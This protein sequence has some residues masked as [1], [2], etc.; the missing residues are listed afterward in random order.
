MGQITDALATLNAGQLRLAFMFFYVL[1]E[2]ESEEAL[3]AI[4]AARESWPSS[5][6]DQE[7]SRRQAVPSAAS[8]PRCAPA[9][10]RWP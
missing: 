10:P 5:L 1:A 8:C 9:S 4:E 7:T 6:L 3:K 2:R